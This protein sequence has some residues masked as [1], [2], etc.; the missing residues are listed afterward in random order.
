MYI[1][2]TKKDEF[3]LEKETSINIL[4]PLILYLPQIIV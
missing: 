1:Y 2:N 3:P 4:N